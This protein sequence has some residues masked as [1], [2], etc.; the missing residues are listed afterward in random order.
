MSKASHKYISVIKILLLSCTVGL[1]GGIVGALF[2]YSV[3]LVTEL[4]AEHG[5][6][7]YLLPLGGVATAGI[8]KLTKLKGVSTNTILESVRTQTSV[9]V[10][11]APVMFVCTVI[12]H[13][14]GGSAGREG[15]ALQIGG[16]IASY[17]SGLFKLD[18]KSRHTLIQCGMAAMFSA[19]FGTPFAA[20]HF[21]LEVVCVGHIRPVAVL[22]CSVSGA[23]SFFVAQKCGLSPERFL[24]SSIP[25]FTVHL[26]LKVM[27]IAV[28]A[29]VLS[30]MFCKLLHL[31]EH[32]I[33]QFLKNE[34]IRAFICGCTVVIISVL[35]NTSDYNGGGL[36]VISRIFTQGE[37]RS[38]AF[39]LKILLT[40]L[41]VAGGY[42]GGEI[43][44]S[45]FIGATFGAFC[46][47]L[48]GVD[49]AFAAAVS[50]AAMFC[51]ISKC[52]LSS[53]LISVE[54]FGFDGV[55][56][57]VLA[58]IISYL[59]SG[60]TGIFNQE[61]IRFSEFIGNIRANNN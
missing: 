58:C 13:L 28:T 51:G 1:A 48:F 61:R 21:A 56:Y 10:R 2:S 9:P 3:E 44:P 47:G 8:Y 50:A 7:I 43:V 32:Y 41:T 38:E 14:F 22:P 34:F 27:M 54:L 35:L 25:D 19:L 52:L 53:M 30:S 12:T 49:V 29:A 18:E 15:A 37:Y 60:K 31:A 40:V 39:L 4:R 6:L 55:G 42:K 26:I 36:N 23:I 45:L 20:V 33:A 11:I 16:G 46:G 24:C 57:Y 5:W 59:S 17:F